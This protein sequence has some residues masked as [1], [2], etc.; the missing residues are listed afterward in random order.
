MRCTDDTKLEV[1]QV[2][3]KKVGNKTARGRE[4]LRSWWEYEIF[5]ERQGVNPKGRYLA[6]FRRLWWDKVV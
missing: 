6:V 3:A 5:G 1:L 4:R 2:L